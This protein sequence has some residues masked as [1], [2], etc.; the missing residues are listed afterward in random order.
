MVTVVE[1]DA[2]DLLRPL[3]WEHRIYSRAAMGGFVDGHQHFWDPDMLPLPWMT[4][5]HDAIARAF[6]PD[7]LAPLLRAHGIS[8]TILVQSANLDA[9]TDFMFKLAADHDWIAAVVAWVPL[10]DAVRSAR[11]LAQLSRQPKLR[12]VRHLIHDELDPH[13]ITRP[14]VLESLSSLEEF[15]LV[16]EL[17]VVFPRHLSDVPLLA[18]RFPS[19]RLVIDHLGKPPIGRDL[20]A[21]AGELEAAAEH[22]N[23]AAKISGLNTATTDATWRA[24]ELRPCVEIALSLFGPERLLCGSDWPVALLNGDY[25]R[26]WQETVRL[27]DMLA[28]D[29]LDALLGGTARRLYSFADAPAGDRLTG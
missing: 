2:D 5:E 23:V 13:W 15:G 20:S 7:D 22:G 6:L 10:D 4:P 3:D 14:A 8:Q 19:L 29:S 21:W 28:P 17:P 12:G 11:R 25:G 9:D 1:A 16:L 27:L 24:S 18:T 26:V